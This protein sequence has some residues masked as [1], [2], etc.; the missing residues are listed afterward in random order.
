MKTVGT[1]IAAVLAVLL[2]VFT[3]ISLYEAGQHDAANQAIKCPANEVILKLMLNE[4]SGPNGKIAER[5]VTAGGCTAFS[6]AAYR[7]TLAVLAGATAPGTA[8]APSGAAKAL[9]PG[10]GTT[11]TPGSSSEEVPGSSETFATN[12]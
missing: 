1:L 3:G 8:C 12:C 2:L 6:E 5:V 11:T 9:S 10:G 7:A 4:S